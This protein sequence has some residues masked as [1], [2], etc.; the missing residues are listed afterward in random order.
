MNISIV[1]RLESFWSLVHFTVNILLF[2]GPA[3][4]CLKKNVA[5]NAHDLWITMMRPHTKFLWQV[6]MIPRI[7][8]HPK[9]TYLCIPMHVLCGSNQRCIQNTCGIVCGFFMKISFTVRCYIMDI[10]L[11]EH[12]QMHI[13]TY[14]VVCKSKL[15]IPIH[16]R[17]FCQ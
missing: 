11:Y 4:N 8:C 17:I 12:L 15:G 13:Y 3:T 10:Y 9:L 6:D 7:F 2:T 1:F 5:C 16:L 14:P